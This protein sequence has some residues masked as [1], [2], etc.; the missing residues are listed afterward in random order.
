MNWKSGM[1]AFV[2]VVLIAGAMVLVNR[3]PVHGEEQG[4]K[5]GAGGGAKY[6][7][8]ETQGHNLLV[9]DNSTN[10]LYYYTIDKDEKIGADLHLRGS[11]DLNQV[12]KPVIKITKAGK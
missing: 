12:G 7:V 2:G 1:L 3:G 6:T 10:T 5:G 9:T 11:V 4:G 8:V